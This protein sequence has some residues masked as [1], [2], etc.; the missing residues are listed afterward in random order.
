MTE[1]RSL[2]RLLGLWTGLR[3]ALLHAPGVAQKGSLSPYFGRFG[4]EAQDDPFNGPRM[5]YFTLE[6]LIDRLATLQSYIA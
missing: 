3:G 4:L 1:H 6:G 2:S 5:Q